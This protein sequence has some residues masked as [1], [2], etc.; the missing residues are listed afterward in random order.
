MGWVEDESREQKIESAPKN[1]SPAE[2]HFQSLEEQKWDEFVRGLEH[3]TQE[4]RRVTA[5]AGFA[6]LSELACRVSNP[7]S[8]VALIASADIPAHVIRYGYEAEREN[9]LV[10]EGGV[11][12][13]R[14]ADG[15]VHLYSADQ[16]LT[17]EQARRLVLEPLL[18][19]PPRQEDL[20][21]TGT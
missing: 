16:Q 19:P 5:D 18:F 10:P 4:Y 8:G 6:Q 7:R 3:D 17:L 15:T 20:R 9:V 2:R 13:M 1:E 11:L 12:T 14:T 21:P